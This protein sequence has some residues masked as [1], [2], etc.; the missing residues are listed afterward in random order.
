MS[1][2]DEQLNIRVPKELRAW[3]KKEASNQERSM[4]FIAVKLLKQGKRIQ[5]AA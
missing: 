3:I 5:E 2:K 1:R 4:N